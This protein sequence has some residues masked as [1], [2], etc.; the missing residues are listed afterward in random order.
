[1]LGLLSYYWILH[2]FFNCYYIV[3]ILLSF[4]SLRNIHLFIYFYFFEV[5]RKK[6]IYFEVFVSHDAASRR[7][8]PVRQRTHSGRGGPIRPSDPHRIGTH[9]A[10]DHGCPIAG[11][12]WS[13]VRSGGRPNF[14]YIRR[15][16]MPF[17]SLLSFPLP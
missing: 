10:D 9:A 14:P 5:N 15:T 13:T 7:R 8:Q 2:L 4:I 12:W 17:A 11:T 6:F 16:A 3:L 1:V